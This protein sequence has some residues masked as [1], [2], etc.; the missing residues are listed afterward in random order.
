[1]FESRNARHNVVLITKQQRLPV[2]MQPDTGKLAE[3]NPAVHPA[4]HHSIDND[5]GKCLP[6]LYAE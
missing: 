2:R 5:P 1:M 4:L 3:L 6:H